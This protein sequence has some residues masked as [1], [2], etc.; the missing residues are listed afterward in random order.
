MPAALTTILRWQ[1]DLTWSLLDLHLAALHDEDCFWEPA[2]GCWTVREVGGVW[3]PDWVEPEPDPPP[4]ATIGWLTWHVGWWWGEAL[5]RTAGQPPPPRAEVTWPGS[6][7]GAVAWLRGLRARWVE[8]LDRLTDT[9]LDAV[10]PYPWQDRPDRTLAHLVAWLNAE[11]MK[12]AA[13]IGQLRL[14]R[15]AVGRRP[16]R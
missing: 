5:A 15:L 3:L 1:H 9:D 10:A 8:V 7:A 13:E 2:A 12:N 6:A 14:Q 4:V 16:A 11:L